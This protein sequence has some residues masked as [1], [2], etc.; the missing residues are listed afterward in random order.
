MDL[1]E[2][3]S[4]DLDF[5]VSGFQNEMILPFSDEIPP[6]GWPVDDPSSMGTYFDFQPSAELPTTTE[7]LPFG[8]PTTPG[9]LGENDNFTEGHGTLQNLELRTGA[10]QDSSQQE[11]TSDENPLPLEELQVRSEEPQVLVEQQLLGQEEPTFNAG[12][13]GGRVT[14]R[15]KAVPQE[16]KEQRCQGDLIPGVFCFQAN[17]D[18]PTFQQRA[19]HSDEHRKIIREMRLLGA[20]LRCKQLKKTVSYSVN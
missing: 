18:S 2:W 7:A 13:N 5:S 6:L 10:K 19:R 3:N 8:N 17:S 20:C 12:V 11:G 9:Q 15:K 1:P 14:K 4:W 16:K